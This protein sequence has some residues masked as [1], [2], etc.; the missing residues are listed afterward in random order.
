MQYSID[1]IGTLYSGYLGSYTYMTKD[2]PGTMTGVKQLGKDF[3]IIKDYRVTG[4]DQSFIEISRHVTQAV[5][6][7]TVLKYWDFETSQDVFENM[8]AAA[9]ERLHG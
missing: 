4:I 8:N 3:A 6:E 1:I 5:R 9:E 2:L 7:E